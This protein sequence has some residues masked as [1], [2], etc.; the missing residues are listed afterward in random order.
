MMKPQYRTYASGIEI[1]IPANGDK[2]R[3]Y[4]S[5]DGARVAVITEWADG[6][7]VDGEVTAEI[8]S[9]ISELQACNRAAREQSEDVKQRLT[10]AHIPAPKPAAVNPLPGF[11]M[12]TAKEARNPFEHAAR[13]EKALALSTLFAVYR[14]PVQDVALMTPEQWRLAAQAAGVNPP[15][16]RTQQ[17]II[18]MMM[19]E[20]A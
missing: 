10:L 15:S 17:M 4:V 6:F 19:R 5:H 13:L 8:R 20:A 2:D 16:W 3:W 7:T 9:F 11:R 12:V 1:S 18:S 14:I